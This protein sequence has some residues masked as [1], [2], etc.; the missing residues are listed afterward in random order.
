MLSICSGAAQHDFH[1][2]HNTGNYGGLFSVMWDRICGTDAYHDFLAK[3]AKR[4]LNEKRLADESRT[5]AETGKEGAG[6]DS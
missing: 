6:K 5:P 2:S 1:H 3:Q 4:H